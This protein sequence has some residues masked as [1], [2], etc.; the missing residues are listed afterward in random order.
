MTVAV[1]PRQ[2]GHRDRSTDGKAGADSWKCEHCVY[3]HEPG[4]DCPTSGV[5]L[6]QRERKTPR[7]PP[8]D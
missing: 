4:S 6:S 8:E 7:P 5:W 1:V 3:R 2:F